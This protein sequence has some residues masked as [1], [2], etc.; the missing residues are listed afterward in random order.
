[1][2][3]LPL[4][5]PALPSG[6]TAANPM[7]DTV[8]T[9]THAAHTH[10]EMI[11]DTRSTPWAPI[12]AIDP[13]IGSL[14]YAALTPKGDILAAGVISQHTSRDEDYH[15]RGFYMA[16]TIERRIKDISEEM[17]EGVDVLIEV[18]A[19]WFCERGSASKDNEAVQKLYYQVGAIIG[20]LATLPYVRGVWTVQPHQWKGQTPKAVMVKRALAYASA[21]GVFL[22]EKI[23]HD[24]FEALLLGVYGLK[25]R[26]SE[27]GV[28]GM[29]VVPINI[30]G[31]LLP[32]SFV[33]EEFID[34]L[35]QE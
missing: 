11:L 20:L 27:P 16:Q 19:N 24:T 9:N 32:S 17:Q 2:S 35:N 6:D 10:P 3:S 30:A 5:D 34:A 25:L 22:Q 13:S 1:M 18:P 31:T 23:P 28:Y 26:G 21:Q 14:G 29:P 12:V 15:A 33:V 8:D 4:P 7:K